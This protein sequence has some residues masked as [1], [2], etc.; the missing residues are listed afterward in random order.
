MSASVGLDR[1]E[2]DLIRIP[3]SATRTDQVLEVL[4]DAISHGNLDTDELL[5]V[6][7]LATQLGVSRTPVREALAAGARGNRPL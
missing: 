1:G 7:G 3:A 5:S 6:Q 2:R 4:R